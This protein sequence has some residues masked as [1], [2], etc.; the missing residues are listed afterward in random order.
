MDH[1]G[2]L[3]LMF[4]MLSCMFIAALWSPVGK[5][6]LLTLLCLM[7]FCAF[8]SF[9]CIVLG[10]VW[11]LIVSIPDICLHTYFGMIK[12]VKSWYGVIEGCDN[13]MVECYLGWFKIIRKRIVYDTSLITIKHSIWL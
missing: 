10:Q 2:Y 6:W 11:F 13:R 12:K 5:G 9:P 8:V 3:S 1:F 7:F 4:V